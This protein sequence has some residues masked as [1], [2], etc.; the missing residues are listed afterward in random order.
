MSK[1]K[2]GDK[3]RVHYTGKLTD[4]SVFDSSEGRDPLEFVVGQGQVIPGF[5]MALMEME[6]GDSKTVE[7]PSE[8][9]YGESNP[10]NI[11]EFPK[12]EFP[13]DFD[14]QEGI[15]LQLQDND[16]N[17]IPVYIKEVKEDTVMLDANFPLAGK[18]LI[19]DIELVS[20]N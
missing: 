20:I 5:D 16:G 7:I 15:Q 4:G 6:V 1:V 3:V 9:A 10:E 13:A 19:F 17:V 14:I 2:S 12:S 18:D 8:Q 11:V